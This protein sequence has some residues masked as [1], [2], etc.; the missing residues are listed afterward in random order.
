MTPISVLLAASDTARY[1][2]SR[3]VQITTSQTSPIGFRLEGSQDDRRVVIAVVFKAKG[4]EVEA[5]VARQ[6]GRYARSHRAVAADHSAAALAA[7]A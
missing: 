6:V 2:L 4:T 1:L 7:L 5:E 3:G